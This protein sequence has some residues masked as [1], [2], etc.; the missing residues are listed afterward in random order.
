MRYNDVIE[1]EI[2]TDVSSFDDEPGTLEEIKRHLSLQFDTSGSIEF[3][4]D[5]TKLMEIAKGARE[6]I[7]NYTGVAMASKTYKSILRN[8]CGGVE[9]PFGPITTLTNIKD[10]AGVELVVNTGYTV[11]GNKFKWIESPCSCYLEVNYVAGYTKEDI[12]AGL[13]RAWLEQIAFDYVNAG[14]QQQ[15]YASATVSICESAIEKAGPYKRKSMI[16]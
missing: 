6:V 7:E 15:Q 14:D 2:V 8:D 12:P 11:R 4:D 3:D 10:V 1:T 13:K 9:I 5:D 16:A